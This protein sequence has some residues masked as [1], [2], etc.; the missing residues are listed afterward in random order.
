MSDDMRE[1]GFS[2]SPLSLVFVGMRDQEEKIRGK[3]LFLCGAGLG[4]LV[5]AAQN[6]WYACEAVNIP[7]LL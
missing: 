2:F 3:T 1:N 4:L 5:P 7:Y 6:S